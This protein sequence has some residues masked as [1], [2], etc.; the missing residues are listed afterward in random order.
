MT[1]SIIPPTNVTQIFGYWLRGVEKH[2]KDHIQ[3]GVCPFL[4]AIWNKR[5]NYIFLT[6]QNLIVHAVRAFGYSS[7][8]Y[9]V[10]HGE[11]SGYGY[12]V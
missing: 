4:W 10:L 8:L 11:A 2:D 7:D 12:W 1:L 6:M 3:V 5:N 9:M